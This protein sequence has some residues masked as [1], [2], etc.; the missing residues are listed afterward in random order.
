MIKNSVL[1]IIGIGFLFSLVYAGEGKIKVD[2]SPQWTE[3][4]DIDECHLTDQGRND[5]FILEPG[6][7]L[8]LQGIDDEDTVTL[9]I[10][11]L[12][13]TEVIDGKKTR[14]VEERESTNGNLIEVSRNFFAFCPENGSIF[15]YGEDVDI[16][17]NG[18]MVGHEG[19]WRAGVG[20]NRFGLMMPGVALLGARY[21]QEWAPEIAMDRVEIVSLDHLLE[22]PA[23][24][25]DHCLAVEETSPLEPNAREVKVYAPGVGLIRDGDLV[26][27]KHGFIGK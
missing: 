2:V 27:I 20:N 12:D 18:R 25:F 9:V 15:Y 23:G 11:V 16:Y 5:Y 7:Q 17:K 24:E 4:F 8:T 22:T 26:L 3:S 14:I 10:T 6:Y 19:A 13:T 21:F 1:L